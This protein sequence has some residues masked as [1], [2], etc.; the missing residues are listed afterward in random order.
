MST[1]TGTTPGDI[2]KAMAFM[3]RLPN[4]IGRGQAL[5]CDASP[6]QCSMVPILPVMESSYLAAVTGSS[7]LPWPVIVVA[8][9]RARLKG[10]KS[11]I[12]ACFLALPQSDH[13]RDNMLFDGA[14][15]NDSWLDSKTWETVSTRDSTTTSATSSFSFS[16][17]LRSTAGA[18]SILMQKI[19]SPF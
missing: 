14:V 5:G 11:V 19:S 1:L 7:R 6:V 18:L 2:G 13:F 15:E 3:V 10:L 16:A 9:P 8:C 4:P 17:S 12:L